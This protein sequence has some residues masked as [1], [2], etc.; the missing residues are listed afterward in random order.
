MHPDTNASP[1]PPDVLTDGLVYDLIYNPQDT[2]LLRDAAAAG[3]QTI[4]GLD[5]L[6][7]QAQEQ[8]HWWTGV[9]APAG[10]MRAAAARKLSEHFES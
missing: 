8:F 9:R 7:A 5:M 3:C 10:V 4:G 6:V 2:K 1:V